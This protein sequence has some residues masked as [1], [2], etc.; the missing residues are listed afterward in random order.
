MTEQ[1]NTRELILEVLLAVTRDQVYSHIAIRSVLEKY[2]YLDKR[3][4]SFIKRVSEGTLETMPELDYILGQ[5]SSAPV[6]KMK[7]VIRCILRMS[8][9]QLRYMDTVPAS[10]VCNEAVK[11]AEKKGFR[12]LKGFVNGVLRHIARGAEEIRWPEDPMEL[13]ALHSGIPGWMLE[14]WKRDYGP[15]RMGQLAAVMRQQA[16]TIIRTNTAL[17]RPEEL[18]ERLQAEGVTVQPLSLPEYPLLREAFAI[19]DYDYIRAIPSFRE[20]LFTVQD[21]SSMLVGEMACA[22][23]PAAQ[24]GKTGE[25]D[26]PIAADGRPLQVIDV[27][28]APGGKAIHMAER[29]GLRGQVLARDLTEDKVALIDE[30]IRREGLSNIRTQVWDATVYDAGLAGQADILIADLP[31]SGLGVLR[32]KTDIRY[33]MSEAQERELAALQRQIL[34]TVCAYVRPGGILMYSTCTMDRME[35][36]DN[37]ARFLKEHPDYTLL[38]ERQLF[39]GEWPGDGFYI[40]KMKKSDE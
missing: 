38:E 18:Q 35:N 14:Q 29:L 37:T 13:L 2:Q 32:R 15:E 20:G 17:I 21:I 33:H 22:E 26:A 4:R 8:V 1:I 27:C 24:E 12:G 6:K 34:S 23:L 11:L 16:P 30:N 31:C 7:P 28:A 10:A 25:D 19:S 5:F 36:E 3:D 39:P 9:Y 40:A